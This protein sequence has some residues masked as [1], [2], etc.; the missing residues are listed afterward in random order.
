G[1][2]I[3]SCEGGKLTAHFGV[4]TI[5]EDDALRACRCAWVLAGFVTGDP[6]AVGV[7]I[8]VHAG[9]ALVSNRPFLGRLHRTVGGEAAIDAADLLRGA[10]PGAAFVS[11]AAAAAC[12]AHFTFGAAIAVPAGRMGAELTGR[13]L[14]GERAS[15]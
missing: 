8:A 13:P 11:S 15:S 2:E 14:L 7:R 12:R 4:P 6:T 3:A 1:G 5:G 9:I 10:P